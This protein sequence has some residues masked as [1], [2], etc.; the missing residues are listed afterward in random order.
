[1]TAI[2]TVV[3]RGGEGG[4]RLLRRTPTCLADARADLTPAGLARV[5]TTAADLTAA[6]LAHH[7]EQQA[8]LPAGSRQ[9]V[10]FEQISAYITTHLHDPAL[11]PGS[12]A[13]ALY[14]STRCLHGLF[15]QHAATVGEVIRQQRLARCRR[16]LADPSPRTVPV[17]TIA[18]RWG[19]PRPSD[20]TRTFHAAVGVT[21]SEYRASGQDTDGAHHQGLPSHDLA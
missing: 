6:L 10:L 3:P 17:S 2:H 16:D 5:G 19:Y 1:M 18:M 20:F 11:T 15:Q 14:I 13:A 12:P 8:L 21:P 7:S 9:H 4:G